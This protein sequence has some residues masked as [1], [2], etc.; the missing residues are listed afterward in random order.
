MV[1]KR[2]ENSAGCGEHGENGQQ[3][4]GFSQRISMSAS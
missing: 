4:H 2:K 1:L 3:L